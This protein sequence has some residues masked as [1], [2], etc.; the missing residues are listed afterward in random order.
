MSTLRGQGRHKRGKGKGKH[1]DTNDDEDGKDGATIAKQFFEIS[2]S[3]SST[4]D[5]RFKTVGF[6]LGLC[7]D[8]VDKDDKWYGLSH[9]HHFLVGDSGDAC[10]YPTICLL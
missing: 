10:T 2:Y 4:C 6:E 3:F 1:D 7:L 9:S 5:E 8:Y